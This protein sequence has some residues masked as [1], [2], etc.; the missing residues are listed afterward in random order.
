MCSLKQKQTLTKSWNHLQLTTSR[1]SIWPSK[2]HLKSEQDDLIIF[3]I[4]PSVG[5][6]IPEEIK[7]ELQ[8]KQ[9]Y[10]KIREFIKFNNYHKYVFNIECESVSMADKALQDGLK[11][12]YSIISAHQ[13]QHERFVNLLLCFSC[14]INMK[15]T[16]LKTA[17]KI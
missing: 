1:N 17:S 12:Y 5:E 8:K 16:K 7:T 9:P 10:L 6:H 13:M 2:Y 3:L 14:Y 15:I 4:D 11:C